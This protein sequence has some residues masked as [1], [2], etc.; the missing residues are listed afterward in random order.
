MACNK[1][2]QYTIM[3]TVG[4]SLITFIRMIIALRC[5]SIFEFVN[6]NL[7]KGKFNH[8]VHQQDIQ[9]DGWTDGWTVGRINIHR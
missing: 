4:G 6:N 8:I 7:I 9:M 5:L 1:S 2:D 3:S